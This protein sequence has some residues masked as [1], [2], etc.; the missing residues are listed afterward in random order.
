MRTQL[1]L[2]AFFVASGIAAPL[3]ADATEYLCSGGRWCGDSALSA[4]LAMPFA[5]LSS[6]CASYT[7]VPWTM[8]MVSQD[9]HLFDR[10]HPYLLGLAC[11]TASAVAVSAMYLFISGLRRKSSD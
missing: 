7:V 3:G 8:L 6:V 1:I 11:G 9:L 2:F 4:I 5:L 10:M